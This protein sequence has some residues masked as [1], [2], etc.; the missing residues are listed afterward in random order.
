MR[1][2]RSAIQVHPRRARF[3]SLDGM[4]AAVS[5]HSHSEC[6]R[7]SLGFVPGFA[8]RIPLVAALFERGLAEYQREYGRALDFATLYWRPPLAPAAVIAS[9]REQIEQ[10]LDSKALIS[11]TDHDTLEGPRTLRA[12]G[13]SDVPLSF[14]WSVPFEGTV[15][16][17]GVHGISPMRLDET[18]RA[19]AAYTAGEAEGLGDLLDSLGERPET[20]VVFN[21]PYW[22]LARIGQLRHDSTLLA[23]LRKHSDRIHALELNGYRT[24]T[25]NR[26]VLP[27]AEGFGLPVV[28]G[29]DR[30]G[31][32]PNTI[33]NLTDA[34]CLAEF[35]R[36]LRSGVSHCVVF[37]EYSEPLVS[38][39]LQT[40]GG[41]LKP[42]HQSGRCT[43]A[44][45]VFIT[46]KG[47]EH[48]A[49]SMWEGAPW[50]LSGI[51]MLTRLLGSEPFRPLFE[52][53]RSDGHGT[54]EEDCA[55]ET[56][57]DR[58]P[59]LATRGSAAVV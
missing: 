43:W 54:L 3:P 58:V 34:M 57:F 46:T 45:R 51:V 12:S 40:A 19:L 27:L 31:Y 2:S 53:T 33:V 22:D 26:R 5:L 56:A 50:W 14:E 52:L 25:E 59:R 39:V 6:S 18:E 30:H 37:P 41:I 28:G 7:E 38:R 1:L 20:F 10:R 29:G 35:A 42:D 32:T 13:H 17:L 15:F 9:E 44:E 16:H 21:H 4:R 23:F 49:D 8:R 24:W 48:S 11:L 47:T 55:P 36:E